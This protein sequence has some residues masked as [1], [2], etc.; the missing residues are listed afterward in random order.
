M[1]SYL[2]RQFRKGTTEFGVFAS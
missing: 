2:N 1:N